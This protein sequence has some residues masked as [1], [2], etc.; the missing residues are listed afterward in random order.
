M[1]FAEADFASVACCCFDL[2]A[3]GGRVVDVDIGMLG[4]DSVMLAPL[5]ACC[6]FLLA[7]LFSSAETT[8]K[9]PDFVFLKLKHLKSS[10]WV[11]MV[12]SFQAWIICDAPFYD[13]QFGL[14]WYL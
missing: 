6:P 3:A 4:D 7:D 1:D 13:Q 14:F 11:G 2:G 12:S 5:T 8:L 9:N 10:G